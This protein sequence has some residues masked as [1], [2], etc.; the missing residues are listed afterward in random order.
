MQALEFWKTVIVDRSNFLESLIAAL[1][2]HQ[3]RYS[4]IGGQ[5]VNAYSSLSSVSTSISLYPSTISKESNRC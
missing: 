2:S 1:A 4:V 3:I 5:G